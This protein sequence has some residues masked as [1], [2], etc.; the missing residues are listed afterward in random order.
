MTSQFSVTTVSQL[1]IGI[2]GL[3]GLLWAVSG[4]AARGRAAL[5]V[6][7]RT[8]PPTLVEG[9]LSGL[10]IGIPAF[11]GF[12]ALSAV[13]GFAL[14]VAA[15]WWVRGLL[16][17]CVLLFGGA[18]FLLVYWALTPPGPER[19][20]LR[21]HVPGAIAFTVAAAVVE[22]L[23]GAYVAYVTAHTSVL[24]GALGAIFGLLAFLYMTMWVFLLGAEVSQAV[25]EEHGPE[26]SAT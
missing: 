2:A 14:G 18:L 23:G 20:V 3:V 15:P 12:I 10:L 25:R 6:V 26:R 1:G 21:E 17:G 4:F 24:Y 16:G 7:F 5:G 19:P 13:A 9:R 8:G 11:A 22:R